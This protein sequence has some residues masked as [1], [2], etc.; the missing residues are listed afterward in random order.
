MFIHTYMNTYIHTW[1]YQHKGGLMP[2]F[3]V[4]LLRTLTL[5]VSVLETCPFNI[6][7][8]ESSLLIVSKKSSSL[9]KY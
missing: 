2:F 6:K 4:D 1:A 8:Q 3:E 7:K 9:H 5:L